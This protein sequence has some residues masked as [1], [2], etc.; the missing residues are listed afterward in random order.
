ML[1]F[2]PLGTPASWRLLVMRPPD[3]PTPPDAPVTLDEVQALADTY[4]GG[5]VR[6]HDPVWMTN[7]R[8]HHRAADPLPRRAGLSRR[9]RRAHPLAGRCAGHEHRHPGR[10]QPRLETRPHPARPRQ[11]GHAG[12]LRTRTRTGR[13]DGAALHRPRVHHRHLHQPAHSLRPHPHRPRRSSRSRSNPGRPCLRLPHR[14]PA[15]HPL[16]HQ[17]A[18]A[19]RPALAPAR[20]PGRR[21]A[22]RRTRPPRWTDDEPAQRHRRARLAPAALR[23]HRQVAHEH[24]D[25]RQPAVMPASSAMH[26]LSA[27]NAPGVLYDSGGPRASPPRPGPRPHRRLPGTPR[28]PCGLPI[29]RPGT[30][31]ARPVPAPLAAHRTSKPAR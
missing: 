29:R 20:T 12:H 15:G 22:P 13:P 9:R 18:V 3:D 7:F 5:A 11:P 10:R 1:F 27:T 19:Q 24:F 2:F 25:R 26:Y 6:V 30:R 23:P 8:L 28:R 14:L 4:T 17:P 31:R 21:P 16:P